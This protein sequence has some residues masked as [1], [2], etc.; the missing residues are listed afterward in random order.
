M[1]HFKGTASNTI[2]APISIE[3]LRH[4]A[5]FMLEITPYQ[6]DFIMLLAHEIKIGVLKLFGRVCWGSRQKEDRIWKKMS[7]DLFISV[8]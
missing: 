8:K 6:N 4:C 3:H 7:I 5:L 1:Y 2:S